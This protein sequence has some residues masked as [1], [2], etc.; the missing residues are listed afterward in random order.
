MCDN[1][2]F[3]HNFQ[4]WYLAVHRRRCNWT[5]SWLSFQDNW[6]H[7]L[8]TKRFEK[9][10]YHQERDRFSF[11]SVGPPS[12]I[13][14]R[15]VGPSG[16][17]W[18]KQ[19]H[20][21]DKHA[22]YFKIQWK[23]QYRASIFFKNEQLKIWSDSV[24]KLFDSDRAQDRYYYSFPRW[25]IKCSNRSTESPITLYDSGAY[26]AKYK[27]SIFCCHSGKFPSAFNVTN[28]TM[29]PLW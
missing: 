2:Y 23:P 28:I 25:W 24:W 19:N 3:A 17:D 20:R 9:S 18:T 26:Q 12:F 13:L 6:H 8:S 11:T 21:P 10:Y 29:S 15:L 16:L 14:D 4:N 22:E 5:N 27:I 7:F 1:N